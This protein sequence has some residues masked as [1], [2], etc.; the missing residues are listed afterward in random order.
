VKTSVVS[1]VESVSLCEKIIWIRRKRSDI[2]ENREFILTAKRRVYLV[3]LLSF[4]LF[5]SDYYDYSY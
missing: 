1:F 5:N 3:V 4:S 2:F